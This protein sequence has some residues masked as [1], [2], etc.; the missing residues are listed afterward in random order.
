MIHIQGCPKKEINIFDWFEQWKASN[1]FVLAK[2]TNYQKE[3]CVKKYLWWAGIHYPSE[4]GYEKLQLYF[5][6]LRLQ[7]QPGTLL[8]W[9]FAISSF[10]QFL[11]NVGVLNRDPC[12]LLKMAAA[13]SLTP[14]YLN[15][16]EIVT[17]I[18]AIGKRRE[19][20]AVKLAIFTG[21]RRTELRHM[22]WQDVDLNRRIIK[23]YNKPGFL[24]KNRK[25]RI[26]PITDLILE[27]LTAL[28]RSIE[29]KPKD[30]ILYGYRK[31]KPLSSRT[32][33]RMIGKIKG[34]FPGRVITWRILRHTFASI[35]VQRGVSLY[36]ISSWM[37]NGAA[38]CEKYYC[39]AGEKFDP[40]INRFYDETE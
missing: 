5:N 28:S 3:A 13:V 7:F 24:V 30:Y 32:M 15:E 12:S 21:L 29:P 19:L 37:G 9:K 6:T 39:N 35:L 17:F 23:V 34:I 16:K 4:I 22:Q 10:C 18:K 27:E 33:D 25:N 20:L 26:V 1:E 36:K 2:C 11:V 38:V 8:N 14:D 40:E 31:D